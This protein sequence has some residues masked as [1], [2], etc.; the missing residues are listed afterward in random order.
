MQKLKEFGAM[1]EM[2][3]QNI[4][5]LSR[6]ERRAGEPKEQRTNIVEKAY[7]NN[8]KQTKARKNNKLYLKLAE[9]EMSVMGKRMVARR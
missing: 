8:R 4:K 5:P 1:A 6:R 7:S 3:T 9:Y 2:A